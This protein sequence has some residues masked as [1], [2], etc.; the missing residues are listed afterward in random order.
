MSQP[1]VTQRPCHFDYF[2]SNINVQETFQLNGKTNL[3]QNQTNGSRKWCF[4]TENLYTL[5]VHR[6]NKSPV[7]NATRLL[8]KHTDILLS[9]GL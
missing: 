5:Y 6:I 7:Q 9:L 3:H 2:G 4:L 8:Q 1:A